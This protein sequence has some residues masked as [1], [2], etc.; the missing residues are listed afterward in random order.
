MRVLHRAPGPSCR[1]ALATIV[2][3]AACGGDSAGGDG[4]AGAV[5]GP[6]APG[7]ETF[8]TLELEFSD[9]GGITLVAR[10]DDPDGAGGAAPTITG[11]SLARGG[12]YGLAIRLYE[13]RSVPPREL[14]SSIRMAGTAHQVFFTAAAGDVL[15][16][17]FN[18]GDRDTAGLPIG[19]VGAAFVGT[20][21]ASVT[22][23]LRHLASDGGTLKVA[24]L[25]DVA[26]DQGLGALPG[27]ND[28]SVTLPITLVAP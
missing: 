24:G 1:A 20:A 25:A 7:T 13:K 19:L 23:T 4:D 2:L 21:G 26:R 6:G 15:P 28:L 16:F 10:F 17:R 8:T 12:Q 22:V 27:V 3:A 5:D 18:Y 9:N 14:T 11:V